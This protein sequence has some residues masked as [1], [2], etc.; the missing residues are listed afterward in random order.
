MRPLLMSVH[1]VSGASFDRMN[2]TAK[3]AGTVCT[4]RVRECCITISQPLTVW[5]EGTNCGWGE[6]D[7]LAFC[8]TQLKRSA[9]TV[10]GKDNVGTS[11]GV[12]N[13]KA[14]AFDKEL[15]FVRH[16]ERG[17]P[18]AAYAPGHTPSRRIDGAAVVVEFCA[19]ASPVERSSGKSSL[20]GRPV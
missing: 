7:T 10:S 2:S 12:A 9:E 6:V 13:D 19:A 20:L 1:N 3:A 14:A 15:Q 11:G 8:G 16:I 4:R 5:P 17:H 18:M